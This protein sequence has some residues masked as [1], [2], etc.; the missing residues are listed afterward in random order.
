MNFLQTQE[1]RRLLRKEL[2]REVSNTA[3]GFFL[4]KSQ[5]SY[6]A[7]KKDWKNEKKSDEDDNDEKEMYSTCQHCKKTNWKCWWRP[8]VVCRSYN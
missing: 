8:D 3:E 5:S 2:L 7:K 6:K 1:Q 4:A